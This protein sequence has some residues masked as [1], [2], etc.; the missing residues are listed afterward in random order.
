M[1]C[2]LEVKVHMGQGHILVPNK[3]RWAHYNAMMLHQVLIEK[4]T[5]SNLDLVINNMNLMNG[6]KAFTFNGLLLD[7]QPC[8]YIIIDH[9][10]AFISKY[11]YVCVG[12]GGYS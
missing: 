10:G 6:S 4:L 5:F 9:V 1:T 11:E 3:G 2:D 12:G 7:K 8:S